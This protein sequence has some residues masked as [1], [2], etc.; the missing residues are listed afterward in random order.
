MDW[1][2]VIPIILGILGLIIGY[3]IGK[4]F[5]KSGDNSIS[6]WKQKNAKLEADLE[7]CRRKL[8]ANVPPAA[9]TSSSVSSSFA[10]G[11]TSTSSGNTSASSSA[12]SF[13]ADGAKSAFGKNIKPDDLKIVEGIGPKIEAL[14]HNHGV[15][16]WEALSQ[17]STE[18]CQKV[19]DSGGSRFRMHDP[20]TWPRQAQLAFEGQWQE[21]HD[22]QDI[23]SGGK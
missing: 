18:K 3:F 5:Q 23:L 10:V 11:G 16:T 8:S 17:C 9:S 14:F 21:L 19:L 4:S 2:I 13:N 1:N 20:K 7:A 12:A 15:K 22:W 6:I